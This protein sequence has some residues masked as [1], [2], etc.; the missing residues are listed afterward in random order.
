MD[1]AIKHFEDLLRVRPDDPKAHNNLGNALAEQGNTADAISHWREAIRL[2]PDYSEAHCNLGIA[3]TEQG[4]LD[5]AIQYF[6][7]A[8]SLAEAQSRSA[9]AADVRKKL[10]A[11]RK[12]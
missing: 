12:R 10:E 3:L 8:L 7:K 5:D 11:I 6:E 4:K 1:E 9:M 2:K